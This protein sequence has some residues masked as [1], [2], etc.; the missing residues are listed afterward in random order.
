MQITSDQFFNYYIFHPL[1]K[2][3]SDLDKAI[4]TVATIVLAIFTL[5][6][7]HG[8]LILYFS[9]KPN[10]IDIPDRV[11]PNLAAN[12]V[13]VQILV[14]P[15]QQTDIQ[16]TNQKNEY[17]CPI[18]AKKIKKLILVAKESYKEEHL[19]QLKKLIEEDK[20][21]IKL[22][23]NAQGNFLHL[24]GQLGQPLQ[25]VKIFA[26]N[27]LTFNLQQSMHGQADGNTPLIWA[28]CNANNEMALEMLNYPQNLNLQSKYLGRNNTAL[29]IA[30]VKGYREKSAQGQILSVSNP[31][32]IKRMV[33][34]GANVAIQN[35]DGNTPLHLAC[36]RHDFEVVQILLEKNPAVRECRNNEG[37]TPQMMIEKSYQERKKLLGFT[38]RPLHLEEDLN[39]DKEKIKELFENMNLS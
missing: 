32:L 16:K 6:L 10:I 1:S 33:E 8:G 7:L 36:L 35:S 28:I 25:F 39:A 4:C 12:N 27:N 37:E 22:N 13:G 31:Q 38:A 15:N 14:P 11:P 3:L 29:H 30:V 26:E 5:G 23:I 20:E 24:L 2:D 34:L 19:F 21:N 18:W 9:W 17:A